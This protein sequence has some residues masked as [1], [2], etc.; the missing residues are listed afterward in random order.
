MY[1]PALKWKEG[2]VEG[3][4]TLYPATKKQVTPIVEVCPKGLTKTITTYDER[5]DDVVKELEKAVGTGGRAYIDFQLWAPG[6]YNSKQQPPVWHVVMAARGKGIA[7]VPVAGFN[8]D[9]SHQ[10]AVRALHT[11]HQ[12]GIC[13]RS[14]PQ[15]CLQPYFAASLM[16]FVGA[17]GA[18][19]ADVDL[20]LDLGECGQANLLPTLSAGA[21]AS[22]NSV[23]MYP[24][25]SVTLLAGAFPSRL[26]D[27]VDGDSTGEIPRLDWALWQSVVASFGAPLQFGDYAIQHIDLVEGFDPKTMNMSG[28]IRYTVDHKWLIHRGSALLTKNP[29]PGRQHKPSAGYAQ[30]RTLAANLVGDPRFSGATFSWGDNE[31]VKVANHAIST[32]NQSKWRA[33]GTNHHIE[34]VV[35]QLTNPSAISGAGAPTPV[36]GPG[37]PAPPVFG[38]GLPGSSTGTP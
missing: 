3:F 20:V 9:L 17:F 12:T 21:V 28:N 25:R 5:L 24:W 7:A 14:E 33:Y 27:H 19:P 2:E 30:Y 37:V 18:T 23:R 16:Q 1:V 26:S 34:F 35:N 11:Q 8:S 36:V 10:Q 6:I 4:A 15:H 38:T 22:L 13:F 29:R 32:G 31:M